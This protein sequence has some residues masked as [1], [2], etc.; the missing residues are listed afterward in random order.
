MRLSD[1]RLTINALAL[2]L[3]ALL[4]LG[5]AARGLREPL[6]A[7]ALA[8]GRLLSAEGGLPAAE[9]F[10]FTAKPGTPYDS[11]GW[12]AGLGAYQFLQIFGE[13]RI[14]A[15]PLGLLALAFAFM[16]ARS[17]R[18]GSPP[19][20][21]ALFSLAAF[22]ALAP[23][24]LSFRDS[25]NLCLFA[26]ALYLMEG[27]YWAALLDRWIY[28]PLI[29]A[30]WVN[31]SSAAWVL[32]PVALLWSLEGA[33]QEQR[34]SQSGFAR[35]AVLSLLTVSLC[36]RPG[37]WTSRAALLQALRLD[38]ALSAE[39][40][41][42]AQ[43]ALGLLGASAA[44]ILASTWT[45]QGKERL[46]SDSTLLACLVALGLL[47]KS[48]L[49]LACLWAAPVAAAR[50]GAIR[51]L[52][53][54]LSA[55]GWLSRLGFL[56]AGL[57]F[58]PRGFSLPAPRPEGGPLPRQ[59]VDFY[60]QQLLSAALLTEPEWGDAMAWRLGPPT[61]LA[62]TSRAGILSS[63]R[64]RQDLLKA[65]RGE[66]DA[67]AALDDLGADAVLSRRGSPL[68]RALSTAVGW[69]PLAFDD[70]SV[71]SLRAT[72]PNAGLIKIHAPRGLRP[73]DPERLF[74][75]SRAPQAEADIEARLRLQP[76]LGVLWLYQ[77]ELLLAKG[78]DARARLALEQGLRADPDFAEGYLRLGELQSARG[79]QVR[80]LA[81]WRI[82]ARLDAPDAVR[83]RLQKALARGAQGESRE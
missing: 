36:L 52:L 75:P 46:R 38:P 83:L 23:L 11:E 30:L 57:W 12:L 26:L 74:D 69:Q 4:A 13:R 68:S 66:A 3:A 5:L 48:L 6:P 63:E 40:L 29:A 37:A 49:P 18:R 53:P 78:Q 82:G 10:L 32:L 70:V 25:L 27:R 80:A 61:R 67:I 35:I 24:G 60:E 79:D 2:A 9:A 65:W 43:G 1:I 56:A 81:L 39:S 64:T 73:G 55:M 8:Q 34:P 45:R 76:G 71:L 54:S 44:L 31:M 21:S 51:A 50:W 33:S 42:G 17:F 47:W 28:L 16:L 7:L 15:L 41:A 58:A 20:V 19:F 14:Q 62:W 22:A 72:P 77:A 59:T